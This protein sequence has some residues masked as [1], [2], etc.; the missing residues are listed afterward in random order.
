MAKS[1]LERIKTELVT[2]PKLKQ[3]ITERTRQLRDTMLAVTPKLCSERARLYTESWKETE[4]QPTV[5]RRAKALEKILGGMSIFIRPGELIVGNQASDVRA[6]PVFPEFYMRFITEELDGKP[7]RF[8]KRPGDP[9]RVSPEDEEILRE[10][11]NWWEGK[12]MTDY[13][14]KLLP[15]EAYKACYDIEAIEIYTWG[16]G[17]GSGHFIADY[18]KVLNKGMYGIIREAEERAK[19]L[20]LWEPGA[21][22]QKEFL[23]AVSIA[24]RAA[25]NFAQRYAVLAREMADKEADQKRKAELIKIAEHCEWVPGNPARTFREA[26]QSLWFAHLIV[27]IESNGHSMGY[28]RFD[29]FIYPFYQK[30]IDQGR[31]TPEEVVELLE[32]LWIKTTE[33]NKVRDWD[34]T[35]VVMGYPMFQQL[36]VGGQTVDGKSAINDLSWLALEA[37]ANQK[38]IQPSLSV[39]WWNECPDDFLLKCCEVINIHR[40]G[41][42]AMYSDEVIIPS[43]MGVGISL[44]DAYDYAIDG[45]VS[46]TEP[47]KARREGPSAG[48]NMHKVLEVALFNG[49]DPRTGIQ[50]CP[51]PGNKDL[52][53]FES[54]DEMM[55]AVKHQ[56]EYYDRQGA[57]ALLCIERAYAE[58]TP[59]PFASALMDDCIQRGKDIEW[60]GAHYNTLFLRGVGMSNVGNSLAAIKKLVFEDKRLT[61]T[62][63]R[64]ALETNFED[65]STTPTGT[66]IQQMLLAAP[67]YGN[68]DDYVDLLVKEPTLHTMRDVRRYTSWTGGRGGFALLPVSQNVPFGEIIGATPDG[69]KAGVPTAEGCSPTRGTDVKGPTAAVKSVAK[70]DHVLADSGSLLNQKFNPAVLKDISGLRKLAALIKT[71]FDLKGMHIQFNVVSADTLR[72]AQKHPE[73]YADLMVRVAGYSALFV[74]LDPAVQEDI[75]MRTEHSI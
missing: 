57:I 8:E 29:Q 36:T 59:T 9:F 68:D 34:A 72:D 67:K 12:T 45:C 28:G 69:R 25:I 56:L 44:E 37:T 52:S 66:E 71:Y 31:I 17:G 62:Q 47:G 2:D 16:E 39:R 63:I 46:I 10:V 3:P 23:E 53:T 6:A 35:R 33:I 58:L 15:E 61:G 4:G 43:Q 64:H 26:V 55:A 73:E 65:A 74:S 22:E 38:I 13:K 50:L 24:L 27:Q 11:A 14:H 7:C 75:I 18:P 54:F 1:Y 41:Q 30:D 60:G 19:H 40:G 49:R 5:I 51:N 70:L 20:K 48:Y 32:C 21:L 42:P